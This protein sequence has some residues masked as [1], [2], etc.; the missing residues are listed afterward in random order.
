MPS[1]GW[2]LLRYVFALPVFP[3]SGSGFCPWTMEARSVECRAKPPPSPGQWDELLTWYSSVDEEGVYGFFCPASS[4]RSPEDEP[5][6]T[7]IDN[8][9]SYSLGGSFPRRT[10]GHHPRFISLVENHAGHR[11][12]NAP[13]KSKFFG[14]GEALVFDELS[15]TKHGYVL[16][17]SEAHPVQQLRVL[18]AD[19]ERDHNIPDWEEDEENALSLSPGEMKTWPAWLVSVSVFQA[20]SQ[21]ESRHFRVR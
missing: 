21:A 10:W 12:D 9:F 16:E 2:F 5:D 3:E 15:Q 13:S 8:D 18:Q 1:S 14:S 7:S 6:Y 4:E 11:R 17:Q 20:Y 19:L